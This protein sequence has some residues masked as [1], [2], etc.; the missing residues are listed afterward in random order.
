MSHGV[1]VPL[2]AGQINAI[3]RR[4]ML[5]GLRTAAAK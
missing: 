2:T 3:I 4:E 1:S 5:A